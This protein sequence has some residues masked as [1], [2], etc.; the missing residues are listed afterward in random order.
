[1]ADKRDFPNWVFL[2]H[3]KIQL[4]ID[5]SQGLQILPK[6]YLVYDIW[7]FSCDICKIKYK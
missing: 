5:D 1:M 3:R 7:I 6:P 2:H 4:D